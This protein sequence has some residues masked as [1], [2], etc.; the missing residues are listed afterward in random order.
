MPTPRSSSATAARERLGG[1]LPGGAQLG[2]E[3]LRPRLRG[4]QGLLRRRG[5]VETLLERRQLL[6][7]RVRSRQQVV[8]VGG[9]EA[10]AGVADPL[11]LALDVLDAVRL[12]L[13]RGQEPAQVGAELAQPQLEIPQLLACACELGCEPFQRS[14]RALGGGGEPRRPVALVGRERLGRGLSSLC[15]LGD[16][17]EPLSLGSERVLRAGLEALGRLDERRQL[18][19]ACLLGGGAAGQ[20]LVPLPRSGQLAPRGSAPRRRRRSCSSPQ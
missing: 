1:L 13:E 18:A 11:Q 7:G 15:Q 19:Q 3:L 2:G 9:A 10:A 5:R 17:A 4:R 16:V 8:V 6:A 12:G 14:E 20:L